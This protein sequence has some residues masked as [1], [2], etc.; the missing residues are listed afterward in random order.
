MAGLR[1]DAFNRRF[2]S[3]LGALAV[4]LVPL[5][6]SFLCGLF[7]ITSASRSEPGHF[8]FDGV[9]GCAAG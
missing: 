8:T 7:S 1:W 6:T 5:G 4:L 2:G 3:G 9:L